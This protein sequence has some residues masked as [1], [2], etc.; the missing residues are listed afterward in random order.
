MNHMKVW[1]MI[2]T[3]TIMGTVTNLTNMLKKNLG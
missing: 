2:M 1:S 3:K